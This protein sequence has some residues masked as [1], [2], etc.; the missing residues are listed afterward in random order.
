MQRVGNTVQRAVEIRALP[1]A[2]NDEHLPSDKTIEFVVR[3]PCRQFAGSQFEG[4]RW[5]HRRFRQER[6]VE[7]SVPMDR[8]RRQCNRRLDEAMA[9]DTTRV[10]ADFEIDEGFNV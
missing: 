9:L 2:R 10:A 5:S 8:T 6:L 1:T 7:G 4:L 3:Q